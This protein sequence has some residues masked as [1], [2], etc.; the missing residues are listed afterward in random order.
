MFD[1]EG[2]ADDAKGM[3]VQHEVYNPVTDSW[4]R[5]PDM[6]IPVH[7]VTGGAFLNGL[8]YLPGGAGARGGGE[9]KDL[10]Q[11]YR[12]SQTCH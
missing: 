9:R 12:P 10:L 2:N 7:G 4:T 5:M 3:F 6:P 8:I 11:T 1:G